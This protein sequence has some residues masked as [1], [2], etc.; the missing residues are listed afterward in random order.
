MK[1]KRILL[2]LACGLFLFITAAPS[3]AQV[4][5]L[6]KTNREDVAGDPAKLAAYTGTIAQSMCVSLQG[7][8]YDKDR[9]KGMLY[10]MLMSKDKGMAP[11]FIPE[12]K[13]GP[14]P[15][16]RILYSEDVK[17]KKT[18][19][20]TSRSTGKIIENG[21]DI[22]RGRE[23]TT[24]EGHSLK[25]NVD[26]AFQKWDG[27][28]YQTVCQWSDEIE[29]HRSSYL[30]VASGQGRRFVS[31]SGGTAATAEDPP[32]LDRILWKGFVQMEIVPGK[33]DRKTTSV[34]HLVKVKNLSPWPLKKMKFEL[35]QPY[36]S[37]SSSR[38]VSTR[39][40]TPDMPQPLA[41]GIVLDVP[42]TIDMISSAKRVDDPRIGAVALS[43][44]VQ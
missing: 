21:Q 29:Q 27:T 9:T 34:D 40:A 12:A 26:L 15:R 25:G 42:F 32:V 44:D 38:L 33:F 13:A 30:S 37:G 2:V 36:E 43:F 28:A 18:Y 10:V 1:S 6:V 17:D 14:N 23:K 16:Y 8:S 41:P 24:S 19:E 31:G 4:A 39:T 35:K 3:L 7:S 11:A 22:G 5:V 20:K